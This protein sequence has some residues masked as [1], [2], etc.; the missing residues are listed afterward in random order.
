MEKNQLVVGL[1]IGTTKI[2]AIVG[3]KNEYGKLEILGMGKAISNGVMRGVVVNINKTVE[4]I[5]KAIHEAEDDAGINI[6]SVNVVTPS[7]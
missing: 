3:R 2:C 1:D 7:V 5:E 4:S 6:G